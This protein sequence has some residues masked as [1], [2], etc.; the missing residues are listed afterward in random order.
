MTYFNVLASTPAVSVRAAPC[1]PCRQQV[2]PHLSLRGNPKF[3]SIQSHPA[4][5]LY[6][7]R[8]VV[9]VSKGAPERP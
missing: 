7:A 6:I 2:E 4:L 1:I 3:D 8:V 9:R 5:I